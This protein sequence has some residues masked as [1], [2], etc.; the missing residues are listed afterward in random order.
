MLGGLITG[1]LLSEPINFVYSNGELGLPLPLGG[2]DAVICHSI[3]HSTHDTGAESS[4]SYRD[5]YKLAPG[6][7][8][9]PH[10][11]CCSDAKL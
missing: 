7:P 2:T 3:S 9:A 11:R 10:E 1:R 5:P 6:P 8:D 4:N